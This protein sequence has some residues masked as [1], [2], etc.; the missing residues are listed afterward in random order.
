MEFHEPRFRIGVHCL[1]WALGVFVVH[2]FADAASTDE[3]AGKHHE[4]E[5]AHHHS[6]ENLHE[7]LH[8]CGQRTNFHEPRVHP[9]PSEP[10][11]CCGSEIQD[12][13]A[14]RKHSYKYATDIAAQ[15]GQLAIRLIEPGFLKILAPKRA[16]N[17]DTG[18]LLTQQPINSV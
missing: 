16:N 18:N 11:H 10:Q 8:E 14:D 17:P 7:V 1:V 3:C 13:H 5:H 9:F 12:E 6:H 2:N 15:P 4:H